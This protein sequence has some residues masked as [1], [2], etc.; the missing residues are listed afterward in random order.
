M[1]KEL[2]W[3]RSGRGG[4]A[5]RGWR[6]GKTARR[7]HRRLLRRRRRGWVREARTPHVR[8][9]CPCSGE[10]WAPGAQATAEG[11]KGHRGPQ[12][13]FPGRCH[14]HKAL[15]SEATPG[16]GPGLGVVG[17]GGSDADPGAPGRVR[18]LSR[19]RGPGK[20]PGPP[21]PSPHS[22]PGGEEP[23]PPADSGPPSRSS[24]AGRSCQP[25]GPCPALRPPTATTTGNTAAAP[26]Q[27]GAHGPPHSPPAS[28]APGGRVRARPQDRRRG[29][30]SGG[31]LPSPVSPPRRSRHVGVSAHPARLT[32]R[33]GRGEREEAPRGRPE[34]LPLSRAVRALPAA[35]LPGPRTAPQPAGAPAPARPARPAH[36]RQ[37]LVVEQMGLARLEA[38]LTCTC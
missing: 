16:T 11:P 23:Q 22:A 17:G 25:S 2:P 10:P 26:D 4:K 20:G 30:G 36:L 13:N 37:V 1:R 7:G 19:Q 21:T 29:P 28:A 6:L 18:A 31:P 32:R 33:P 35:P 34:R 24:K 5:L 8:K 14:P 27:R 9:P 15:L 38:V 3:S 12:P